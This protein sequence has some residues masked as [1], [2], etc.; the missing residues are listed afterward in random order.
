MSENVLAD[1]QF[2]IARILR[3]FSGFEAIYEGQLA[4]R[5]IMLTQVLTPPGGAALDDRAGA[6]GYDPNL[7]RGLKV[8]MGARVLI[9]FPKITPDNTLTVPPI[10]DIRYLWTV[11]W[12]M[13]NT[14]DFRQSRIPYHYPKQGQGVPD[15]SGG[16]PAARVV[17]PG[18]NQTR[19]VDALSKNALIEVYTF[20]GT[21]ANALGGFGNPINPN[22][23]AGAIQQG[24]LDP[25][26]FPGS[27]FGATSSFY[28]VLETQAAGDELL[29][30]L[31]R[32]DPT[33]GAVL[34]NWEFGQ[35]PAAFDREV[36]IFLGIGSVAPPPTGPFPDVG[37][38]VM[39]GS[40]P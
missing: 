12:R 25:A 39:V 23:V 8:P 13:R 11:Q 32:A 26:T 2:G 9:W 3:P 27:A 28:Q 7:V 38:Y 31:T 5:Q 18:A 29:I 10:P 35:N 14:F 20:G 40:A 37:V 24:I 21:Y 1:A 4:T 17:I 6:D 30:G 19:F 34:S 33:P 15:T 22:G 36:S 16:V